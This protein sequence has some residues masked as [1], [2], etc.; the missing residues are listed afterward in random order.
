MP[1]FGIISPPVSGHLHPFGALGRELRSRGHRVTLIHQADLRDKAVAEELEFF[2][3]GQA[4]HPPGS[5]ATSLERLGRL[6]GLAALRYTIQAIGQSTR[7]FCEEG[8]D[9]LQRLG[10]DALLV[11]QTEPVGAC[12]AERAGLPYVSI[13]NALVMD[14]DP[15]IPPP[16]T[17]WRY[18]G[19]WLSHLRNRLGYCA[20]DFATRPIFKIIQ[21][22]RAAW[23][24]PPYRRLEDSSSPLAIIS[25]QPA[26]FDF[27]RSALP[28]HFHY[29]GPLRRPRKTEIPFPWD[30]LTGAPLIYGSL[31]SLQGGKAGIFQIMADACRTLPVQLVLSHGH[32]LSDA[33]VQ[34]L[35]RTCV[36]VPYA[37]QG[38]LLARAQLTLTHGG[39]N[40]VLDSL[41][42]G[43]PM[44]AIPITYEQPAIAERVRWA[45]VGQVIPLSRL[46]VS[47]LRQT[48]QDM[49]QSN[50][51][52]E[53]AKTLAQA[54]HRAG[55]VTKAATLLE[56]V[57]ER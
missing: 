25:Q 31:G 28:D 6:Q 27:P 5:L 14:R 57:L 20:S 16:F 52:S 19:G 50:T 34:A 47:L 17:P 11:D 2:P 42:Q 53:C 29:V 1:H 15:G 55:G 44:I 43:V 39:L 18:G 22:Y 7:M 46:T 30:R 8:P 41:S 26:A 33:A 40:T 49:L 36:V 54:I 48:I 10:V 21:H 35:S 4:S 38:D 45:R 3:I 51:Y 13:C 9:A 12:L 24:L 37:P 32:S 56:S 23:N